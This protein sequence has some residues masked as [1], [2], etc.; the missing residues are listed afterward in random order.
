[1]R[2]LILTIAVL[3]LLV[4]VT[5]QAQYRVGDVLVAAWAPSPN[6]ADAEIVR[7]EVQMDTDT[8]WVV[9]GGSVPRAEYQWAIPQARVTVGNHEVRVRA[10]NVNECGPA[11]VGA[12]SVARVVP[13]PT[14][15]GGIGIRRVPSV[16]VLTLPEAEVRAQAYA[17]L[18]IDRF[19]TPSE[20]G[21]LGARHPG[22]P[23]T[24]DTVLNL[25]DA[26]Y[27]ELVAK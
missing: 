24:R 2:T 11:L 19:L 6:E 23:P 18:T 9:A 13:S 17:L 20:L 12:F 14:A 27:A 26:A 4:P 15:P 10:C 21:W 3:L 5:A 22:V 1:M 8:A 25:M 16:V 7:H